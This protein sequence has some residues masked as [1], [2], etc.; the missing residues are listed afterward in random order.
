MHA[1]AQARARMHAKERTCTHAHARTRTHVRAHNKRARAHAHARTRT[2]AHARTAAI[3]SI[4]TCA[5]APVSG[6]SG[7]RPGG[8]QVLRA[9]LVEAAHGGRHQLRPL[10]QQHRYPCTPARRIQPSLPARPAID[11]YRQGR[12]TA[13]SAARPGP[14]PPA[15]PPSCTPQ[16]PPRRL[17]RSSQHRPALNS[18]LN[19]SGGDCVADVLCL[20]SR[21]CGAVGHCTRDALP[22]EH[23]FANCREALT[24]SGLLW[25]FCCL[26]RRE[27]SSAAQCTANHSNEN[28]TC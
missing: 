22:S 8:A 26:Y 20:P 18:L 7:P 23:G 25:K 11:T 4:R 5:P 24:K 9:A 6:E 1:L 16:S 13:T 17:V 2:H 28:V 10:A 12:S 14:T 21:W 19:V 3:T 27:N 15:A